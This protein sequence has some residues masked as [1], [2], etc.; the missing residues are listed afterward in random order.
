VGSQQTIDQPNLT[1][2]VYQRQ[3]SDQ[4]CLVVLNFSAQDQRVTLPGHNQGHIILST[5]IDRE[6]SIDLS[7][8]HLRGNEGILIDAKEL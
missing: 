8:V 3:H 6:G 5:Y 4:C 1:C 7:A 2:F